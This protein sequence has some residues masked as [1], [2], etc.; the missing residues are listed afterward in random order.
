MPNKWKKRFWREEFR[1]RKLEEVRDNKI[2]NV[3][4]GDKTKKVK[5][6]VIVIK[7]EK[8]RVD[9]YKHYY[10]SEKYPGYTLSALSGF[11]KEHSRRVDGLKRRFLKQPTFR[12]DVVDLHQTAF[13]LLGLSQLRLTLNG[14]R[15]EF[16]F[17]S[18][19]V[20]NKKSADFLKEK[21]NLIKIGK[22]RY[23]LLLQKSG[24]FYLQYPVLISIDIPNPD[25][26]FR[27][28]GI[29]RGEKMIA[30][31]A[32]VDKEGGKPHD[33]SFIR[34][35]DILVP[36]QKYEKIRKKIQQKFT[37]LQARSSRS[38]KFRKRAQNISR[39]RLHRVAK[40]LVQI[41]IANKPIVIVMERI[42][43]IR[44]DRGF[45]VARTKQQKERNYM[46]SNF[47][48]F[49]LQKLI[50]YKAFNQGIPVL[51]V[52]PK[53]TSQLC[54]KCGNFGTKGK[55]RFRCKACKNQIQG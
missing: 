4:E 18:D 38:A 12:G 1:L 26:K 41:A 34:G 43:G 51:Y 40:N 54:W 55:T 48:Y 35:T 3:G 17:W 53:N 33:I 44:E 46:L 19:D 52:D 28:M 42:K 13:K 2:I 36:K 21:V 15:Y 22:P 8:Q 23:P 7:K 49:T 47:V 30:V 5:A 31:S 29:D 14:A 24:E 45:R 9:R 6:R 11:I 16:S 32:V 37:G 25:K 20:R 27:A 10:D 39:Y 50:E